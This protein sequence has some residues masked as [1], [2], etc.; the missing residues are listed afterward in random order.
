MKFLCPALGALGFCICIF[1]PTIGQAAPAEPFLGNLLDQTG[2]TN[3]TSIGI[4][5]AFTTPSNGLR[6]KPFISP[7]NIPGMLTNFAPWV[8]YG[9]NRAPNLAAANFLQPGAY[10][11][12]PYACIVLVPGAHPDERMV[13]APPKMETKMP[14]I[15]PHLKFVPLK[16]GQH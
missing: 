14:M 6:F 12:E 7:T 9:T 1:Q 11:T 16:G 8:F 13:I 15:E 3:Q 10:Q 5:F 4:P 2:I